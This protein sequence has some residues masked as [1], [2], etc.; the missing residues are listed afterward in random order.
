MAVILWAV[1]VINWST[2]LSLLFKL[3]C[4]WS[5]VNAWPQEIINDHAVVSAQISH[6]LFLFDH[7]RLLLKAVEALFYVSLCR[8]HHVLIC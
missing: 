3:K 5:V 1:A 2:R 6:Y 7:F 8:H 4:W